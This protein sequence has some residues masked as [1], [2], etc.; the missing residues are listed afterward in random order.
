MRKPLKIINIDG[1]DGI[2]KTTQIGML[3][4]NFAEIDTPTLILNLQDSIESAIDCAGKTWDFLENNPEGVV[5]TDGSVARMMVLDL[6]N[7]ISQPEI[8][9]KYKEVLHQHERLNH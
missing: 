5:F 1:M 7:G 6:V 2:G 9:D 8:S 3:S 4:K